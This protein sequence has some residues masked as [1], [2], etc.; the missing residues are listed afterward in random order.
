[1]RKGLTMEEKVNALIEEIKQEENK[2]TIAIKLIPN[3]RV[4][5]TSSNVAGVFYLPKTDSI[6]VNENGE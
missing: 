4:S 3:T 2:E 5:L 6:P 1:M